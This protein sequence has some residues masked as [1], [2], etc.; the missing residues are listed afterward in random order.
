MSVAAAGFAIVEVPSWEYDRVH[1]ASNLNA[2][3]DGLRVLR[4]IVTTGLQIRRGWRSVQCRRLD[5]STSIL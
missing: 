5:V 3:Q 1:G 2:V 4:T